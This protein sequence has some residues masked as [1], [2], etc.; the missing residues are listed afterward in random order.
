MRQEDVKET[1]SSQGTQERQ[2]LQVNINHI[3]P[4]FRVNAKTSICTRRKEQPWKR[5][6][7][8]KLSENLLPSPAH[9]HTPRAVSLVPVLA[10]ILP[11]S[12]QKL[13]VS[14]TVLTAP[15]KL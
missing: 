6:R 10:H 9:T 11:F 4:T 2:Y 7:G 13:T 8:V 3:K 12:T 15:I 5:P 14:L 1:I